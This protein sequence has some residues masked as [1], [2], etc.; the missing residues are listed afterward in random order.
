M[1]DIK[2]VKEMD[3]K[4]LEI[5][6]ELLKLCEKTLIHIGGDLSIA[7]IM[8]AIWGYAIKYDA[9]NPQWEK[10]DRF[11]LSKG[12][13]SAVTSFCQAM[14][15]CFSYDDI[16]R[17]Y[18]TDNGRFGMHSCNLLNPY[19]DVSTG[20]LGHGLPVATGIAQGLRLKGNFQ[21]RVFV[22]MGDGEL[23]EGSM[24]EAIMTA[25]HYKL[26]NIVGFVD[27]NG[28]SFDGPLEEIMDIGCLADKFNL[29]GWN[30]IDIDGHDM[31]AL[32]D[33]ID[34]LPAPTSEVPTVVIACTVKGKG[35]DF[36]ENSPAWH[37]GKIDEKTRLQAE[38]QL[39]D[40]FNRKW[41]EV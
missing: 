25:S 21:N 37:A 9:K 35:V 26:G 39:H 16:Y 18:C 40:A 30:A 1:A 3:K 36:M 10:R 14:N 6:L 22:V 33:V 5:R 15:G 27:M 8:T 38:Q 34:E 7:D 11:I 23:N 29:F 41:G 28:M 12:H 19:V 32:L 20:S 24:W 4:A 17:E 31:N 13:A 2:L